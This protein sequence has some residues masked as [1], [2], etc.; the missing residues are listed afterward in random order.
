MK[1]KEGHLYQLV[2]TK[3]AQ[4]YK[5]QDCPNYMMPE[6][7]VGTLA[8]CNYCFEPFKMTLALRGMRMKRLKRKPHCG[9]QNKLWNRPVK[10]V[11]STASPIQLSTLDEIM[12]DL[13]SDEKV[14]KVR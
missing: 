8:R 3:K 7:I 13:A 6:T 5:C 11:A 9:C 1:C 14:I 12:K 10:T 2:K 4:F